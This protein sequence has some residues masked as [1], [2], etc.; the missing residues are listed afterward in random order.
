MSVSA[1]ITQV[2]ASTPAA[3]NDTC[4]TCPTS[5][6]PILLTRYAVVP[7]SVDLS[8]PSQCGNPY[9]DPAD[10]KNIHLKEMRYALRTLREGYVYLYLPIPDSSQWRWM[11]YMVSPQG[12][13]REVPIAQSGPQKPAEIVCHREGHNVRAAI[14]ALDQPE[15]IDTAYIAYSEHWWSEKTLNRY[16][17]ALKG[18]DEKAKQRFVKFHP[19]AWIIN[20]S[21]QAG[22]MV[23]AQGHNR[24]A[25]YYEPQA[26]ER[27]FEGGYY[28][29]LN[30]RGQYAS[31]RQHMDTMKAG[32]G[33]VIALPDPIGCA[34]E[35]NTARLRVYGEYADYVGDPKT[36]WKQSTAVVIE[37]LRNSLKEQAVAEV[38]A[39]AKKHRSQNPRGI[40]RS[41]EQKAKLRQSKIDT[42][43][44]DKIDDIE[45]FY[46][47]DARQ[48]FLKEYKQKAVNRPGN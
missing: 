34:M 6:L 5:G 35:L 30:R 2:A 46:Y 7:N 28:D 3:N 26:L 47:E 32:R 13:L 4:T 44:E 38:D 25:E 12:M 37:G 20:P 39:T 31:L 33:A 19:A 48:S 10:S 11:R 15:K 43:I 14:I 17:G 42:K 41:A 1:L 23:H 16:A 45:D 24:I 27:K 18:K 8:L 9:L 29:Y 21:G 40:I 36:A 22:V